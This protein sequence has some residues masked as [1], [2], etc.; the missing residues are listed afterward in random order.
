[1]NHEPQTIQLQRRE[2]GSREIQSQGPKEN[3]PSSIKA[4]GKAKKRPLKYCP[5]CRETK[6]TDSFYSDSHSTARAKLHG[7]CK[8]CHSERGKT[9]REKHREKIR[10]WMRRYHAMNPALWKHAVLKNKY[11]ISLDEFKQM[12]QRQKGRC[13][14]CKIR[15]RDMPKGKSRHTKFHVDHCHKTGRIR[16]LLCFHCNRRLDVLATPKILRNS[17]LYLEFHSSKKPSTNR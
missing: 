5:R 14:I 3:A 17:A 9:Y 15:H 10:T 11:G 16:A 7:W 4:V 13:A 12:V 2:S 1:M 8:A 6:R